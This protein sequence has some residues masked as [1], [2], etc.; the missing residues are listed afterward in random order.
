MMKRNL[1]TTLKKLTFSVSILLLAAPVVQ[2]AEAPAAPQI[3]AKAYVLMDYNSGKIL[4]EGNADT[5]L[6]PASLTKIMSSYVI[7]QAIKA[8]KIKPEDMVTV[9]KDAWA[10]GNPALRGS[11]LMFIKPGDQVPVMELNKGIVIQSGNDASIA[12]AD[13]VAGSQ[14]SFVG[15]MNNYAK[16]LG[17]QNT[18]FLTVHGLDAE[19]QYS[20]ARDM[21][22]LSQA[23]IRDVPDEY[24]LHKEKEFTFNKIR[25]I[26][27]NRLLWS[28]N[29][30]VDGIKTGYTGGAGHNLVA[31]ATDGPMRLISV[32]L[33]APSDRIRFSES[34]KLLTW[35]F[36][37]YETATPIKTDKPFVTQ[38]VWFGD[39]SEVPL[40]VAKD[41]AVTIPKG[42][43]KNLKASYK[44]NQATLE[45]PL[46]KNQ[47]VGTIDFQLDG[48]TIEQY[49]LVAMQEVKEGNFFSRIWD[50]V[51]MKLTQWFG[52][53]FG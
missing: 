25:Q 8:G 48:K 49:P 24:A 51:M 26:N 2:A 34:E 7:G 13:Y 53:V 31:S 41:A 38:K 42:Q 9:G 46:A 16:S 39:V 33:G 20:T 29:L 4:T 21:A 14:D 5:R 1:S 35:G 19:G 10:T 28:S 32:V 12:L 17:L 44:L 30:N 40:G 23:L 45:A 27:R 18:H 47:V 37:F 22:L 11:S 43:M 36:R 6:D 52:S 50:M 15:L 3:D